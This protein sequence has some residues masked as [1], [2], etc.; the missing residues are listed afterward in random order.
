MR[1]FSLCGVPTL[2]RW[3]LELVDRLARLQRGEQAA[4]MV[5]FTEI[6][7]TPK[8]VGPNGSG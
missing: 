6:G 2:E 1:S 3:C 4:E 7:G 8:I 5:P